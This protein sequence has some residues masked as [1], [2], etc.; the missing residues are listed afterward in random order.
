MQVSVCKYVNQTSGGSQNHRYKD[1]VQT[2]VLPSDVHTLFVTKKHEKHPDRKTATL[3]VSVPD[4]YRPI[5]WT[6][7]TQGRTT[8]FAAYS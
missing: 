7:Q 1:G 6:R 3:G 4:L 2:K 5:G 8:R